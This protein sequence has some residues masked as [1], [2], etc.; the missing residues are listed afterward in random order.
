MVKVG[1]SLIELPEREIQ[2]TREADPDQV[3]R[4]QPRR[5]G[6]HH[7]ELTYG[8]SDRQPQRDDGEQARADVLGAEEERCP[9]SVDDELN[10][11]GRQRRT[12][13]AMVAFSPNDPC[14]S[15]H[16]HVEHGPHRCKPAIG[17]R[18]ARLRQQ[19]ITM[20]PPPPGA[21]G[22]RDEGREDQPIRPRVAAAVAGRAF[23][24]DSHLRCGLKDRDQTKSA[25]AAVICDHPNQGIRVANASQTNPDS[26]S[27]AA[28]TAASRRESLCRISARNCARAASSSCNRRP[29]CAASRTAVR[30]TCG[31]CC[32]AISVSGQ[33]ART[34][35]SMARGLVLARI[36]LR[37][38][39][40]AV[41]HRSSSGYNCRPR[42]SMLNS[43]F[44][45]RINCGCTCM[46]KRRAVSNSR[47]ST[48]AKDM[49]FRG[50]LNIGS[51]T[52]RTAVSSSSTR[53][54]RG[55]H[56]DSTCSAA[57]RA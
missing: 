23:N 33:R 30:N 39:G 20:T 13:P 1:A 28:A 46:S 14:G 42:P 41:C 17:R 56:P 38:Y 24:R 36:H 50:L 19:G 27:T 9:R 49:S 31:T 22:R 45:S 57:T 21:Q 6:L 43:V 53:V 52:V 16:H 47:S 35:R 55:T 44:C 40:C 32:S 37:K 12:S 25:M 5:R 18:P 3:R 29:P 26:H 4:Q 10:C 15:A 7:C 54:P 48:C 2:G 51:Q 34:C 11:V 8:P